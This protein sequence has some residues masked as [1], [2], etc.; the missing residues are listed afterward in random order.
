[1]DQSYE[2][3]AIEFR[4]AR[5]RARPKVTQTD[6]AAAVGSSVGVIS[7]FERKLTVPHPETLK[8]MLR[9]VGVNTSLPGNDEN[10]EPVKTMEICDK[11]GRLKWPDTYELAFDILGNYLD[12]LGS[13]M[14][15]MSYIREIT[16]PV[17]HGRRPF[18]P[19]A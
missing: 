1:M 19:K 5:R 15:R 11:C 3:L 18:G 6:V 8:A 7:N 13:D 16:H 14:E 4:D 10:S 9:F 17:V 12:N 2:A